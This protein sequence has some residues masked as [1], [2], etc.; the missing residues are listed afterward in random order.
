MSQQKIYLRVFSNW[1]LIV[2]GSCF[3]VSCLV[4]DW[5]IS[6]SLFFHC[7]ESLTLMLPG[8]QNTAEHW[9]KQ[10]G[11]PLSDESSGWWNSVWWEN[12]VLLLLVPMPHHQCLKRWIVYRLRVGALIRCHWFTH[13]ETGLCCF[14]AASCSPECNLA[15]FLLHK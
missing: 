12:I 9:R 13:P 8:Q 6:R 3:S 15:H 4:T 7:S 1:L 5:S 14:S 11:K 10:R 2:S